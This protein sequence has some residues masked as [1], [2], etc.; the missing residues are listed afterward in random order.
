MIRILSRKHTG[1]TKTEKVKCTVLKVKD[2]FF[3]NSMQVATV[4]TNA[5]IGI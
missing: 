2:I 4:A 1:A 5:E 3:I